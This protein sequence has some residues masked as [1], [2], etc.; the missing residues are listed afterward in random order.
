M[1]SAKHPNPRSPGGTTALPPAQRGS[2]GMQ[3]GTA[4][5]LAGERRASGSLT[6]SPPARRRVETLRIFMG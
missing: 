3:G 5:V 1:Y 6:P 4:V 2:Y